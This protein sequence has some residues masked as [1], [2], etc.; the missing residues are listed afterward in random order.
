[1]PLSQ[2]TCFLWESVFLAFS[3][4][5]SNSTTHTPMPISIS[6][7]VV[8]KHKLLHKRISSTNTWRYCDFRHTHRQRHSGGVQTTAFL[9]QSSVETQNP[10]SRRHRQPVCITTLHACKGMLEATRSLLLHFL[11]R[12]PIAP[13]PA[14]D[15]SCT[16]SVACA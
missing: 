4:Q 10:T 2:Q 5:L 8:G 13:V 15:S 7:I 14:A 11:S 6:V 1:M 16:K 12:Y 9:P 3:S